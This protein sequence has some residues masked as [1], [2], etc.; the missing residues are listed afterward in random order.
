MTTAGDL[1]HIAQRILDQLEGLDDGEEVETR[2][3]TYGLGQSFIA[4]GDGFID[5]TDI[6]VADYD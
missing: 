3:N 6:E 1:R 2:P 5:Y 4:V